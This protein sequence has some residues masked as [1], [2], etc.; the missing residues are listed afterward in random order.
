[1]KGKVRR[2]CGGP[3]NHCGRTCSPCWRKG[4]PEK[5]VLCNACGAR[6]LVKRNL[7][8]YMPGQKTGGGV[9]EARRDGAGVGSDRDSMGSSD[10]STGDRRTVSSMSLSQT[11]GILEQRR[12]KPLTRLR[13]SD[14]S[15]FR[16]SEHHLMDCEE[17]R[18]FGSNRLGVSL[19]SRFNDHS[20]LSDE[21]YLD[22]LAHAAAC[23]LAML[24]CS[25]LHLQT[26]QRRA[27]QRSA[28]IKP[29]PRRIRMVRTMAD[30][31]AA[32]P[33]LRSGKPC[34]GSAEQRNDSGQCTY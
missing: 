14:D 11:M 13:E 30:W 19:S 18:P 34:P 16:P 26:V 6:Y 15:A 8:G 17:A 28:I 1:M 2:G 20:R 21:E 10:R 7:D 3:C 33:R 31:L 25:G 22:S 9:R 23:T 29:T 12:R 4:P 27:V 32:Y 24:R 5:P